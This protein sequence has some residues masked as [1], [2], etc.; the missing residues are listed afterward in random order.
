[1]EALRRIT[2]KGSEVRPV[3]MAIED[4]HWIDKISEEVLKYLVLHSFAWVNLY[5]VVN[6]APVL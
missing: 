1:M 2:L 5:V 6:L 3:I 4:L